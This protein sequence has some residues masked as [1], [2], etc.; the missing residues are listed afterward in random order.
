MPFCMRQCHPP[1]RLNPNRCPRLST[2]LAFTTQILKRLLISPMPASVDSMCVAGLLELLRTRGLWYASVRY[3]YMYGGM[4]GAGSIVTLCQGNSLWG[5]Q[6]FTKVAAEFERVWTLVV[7]KATVTR[8][9]ENNKKPSPKSPTPQR[10][11]DS[12][13]P[14]VEEES[15]ETRFSYSKGHSNDHSN[16][17]KGETVLASAI[18]L[19]SHVGLDTSGHAKNGTTSRDSS[20]RSIRFA[21]TNATSVIPALGS[22]ANNSPLTNDRGG[23]S[24]GKPSS[25]NGL[26]SLSV[27]PRPVDMASLRDDFIRDI[28]PIMRTMLV[29]GMNTL[30]I[31]ASESVED[32]VDNF[33]VS[34]VDAFLTQDLYTATR[35]LLANAKVPAYSFCSSPLL[36]PLGSH[37]PFEYASLCTLDALATFLF[38]SLLTGLVRAGHLSLP[39]CV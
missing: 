29:T 37:S 13:S 35:Q 1:E 23:D 30:P 22:N 20:T 31:T 38:S 16:V 32:T 28:T 36:S 24:V 2:S 15:F 19:D 39:R 4:K 25:G 21:P 5:K 10:R 27:G 3:G 12:L 33:I 18:K 17:S 9:E 11:P 6:T 26:E 14:C 7:Q 8:R 34:T